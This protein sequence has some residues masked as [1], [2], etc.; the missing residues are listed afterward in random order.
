MKLWF[1][2]VIQTTVLVS[3]IKYLLGHN[4]SSLK[5]FIIYSVVTSFTLGVLFA[6]FTSLLLYFF[7]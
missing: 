1:L 5:E 2:I 3:L 7:Y 6:S 4:K